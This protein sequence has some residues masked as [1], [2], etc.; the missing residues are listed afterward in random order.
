VGFA[1]K[2]VLIVL[3]IT[4]VSAILFADD[5]ISGSEDNRNELKDLR[6]TLITEQDLITYHW[7]LALRTLS[8]DR[9]PFES[10]IKMFEEFIKK[11]PDN[12]P[13]ID[14]AEKHLILL[15][16][17]NLKAAIN[18][19]PFRTKTEFLSIG[20][21]GGNYGFGFYLSYATMRWKNFFWETMRFQAMMHSGF[22]KDDVEAFHK[23]D[24]KTARYSVNL[25]TMCG[26]PFFLD[27][28]NRYEI[29]LGWGFSGG[30]N[31]FVS[32]AEEDRGLKS[33]SNIN[34]P[35]E[36][37]FVAHIHRY[38]AFQIGSSVDI[39]VWFFGDKYVPIVS[40]FAG[41]KI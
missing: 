7:R 21:S 8:N 16:K 33:G 15:K 38:F 40:G 30:L 27:M 6:E 24:R 36:I 18:R 39:P 22:S 34:I 9:I 11:Y 20:F 37:S 13:Y 4:F 1:M 31:G 10:K 3:I 14:E 5:N 25:K 28:G 2:R 19:I 29:R 32:G 35:V 26:V 23:D 17:N 12:N 41:F